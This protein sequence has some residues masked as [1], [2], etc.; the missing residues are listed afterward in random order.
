MASDTVTVDG[1][2][3]VVEVTADVFTVEVTSPG[4][5]VVSAGAAGPPGTAGPPGVGIPPGGD[6]GQMLAKASGTDYATEWVDGGGGLVSVRTVTGD[7]TVSDEDDVIL[8]NATTAALTIT[9]PPVADGLQMTVKKIDQT[10]NVVTI[11]GADG[12]LIDTG[13][14]ELVHYGEGMTVSS[15]GTQWYITNVVGLT[16]R[17]L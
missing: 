9:L 4:V 7:Y 16:S 3:T 6:T 11:E 12:V 14:I 8:A 15:D 5:S 13:W 10:A 17:A 1:S 2:V